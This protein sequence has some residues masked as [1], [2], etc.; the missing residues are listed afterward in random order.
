MKLSSLE[1]QY[2]LLTHFD[3]TQS[4]EELARVLNVRPHRIRYIKSQLTEKGI[5]FIRPFVDTFKLGF[6]EYKIYLSLDT[7]SRLRRTEVVRWLSNRSGVTFVGELASRYD[8]VFDILTRDPL[9][10]RKIL[11]EISREVEVVIEDRLVCQVLAITFFEKTYLAT[12]NKPRKALFKRFS[13]AHT[14]E[15]STEQVKLLESLIREETYSET[16]LSKS[17]GV[18]RTTLQN[19]LKN[20]EQL[21]IIKGIVQHIRAAPLGL[22][23]K[24][25]L[26]SCRHLDDVSRRHFYEHFLGTPEIVV[27]V[28]CIGEWDFELSL[29]IENEE[30]L[31][32][33][34]NTLK[35]RFAEQIKEVLEIE[36]FAQQQPKATFSSLRENKES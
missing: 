25:L 13:T 30:V 2:L 18:P 15:L 12:L 1:R 32:R 27:V 14:V 11:F 35:A 36:F 26:V 22:Q 20:L 10:L 3:P 4:V 31:Q 19:R 5:I 23:V 34:L 17:L 7:K 6:F 29:E 21:G 9:E 33:I 8:L 16:A 28:D 24:R